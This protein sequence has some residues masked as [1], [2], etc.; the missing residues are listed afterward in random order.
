MVN[1]L[2]LK[3]FTVLGSD[4]LRLVLDW[5]NTERVRRMMSNPEKISWDNH[6]A[7]ITSLS[8]RVDCCY[9]LV[10]VGERPI[11]VIDLTEIAADGSYANP[12][13]YTGEDSPLGTGLLLEYSVFLTIFDRFGLRE[14]RSLVKKEQAEYSDSLVRIFN[15]VK[16][17]ETEDSFK[18][19][20]TDK[21]WSAVKSG[22]R[23]RLF[24]RFALNRVVWREKDG[25]IAEDEEA[26]S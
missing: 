9:Y 4:E 26:C 7:Y 19:L 2:I 21:N 16:I 11:G 12:G 22:L 13:L 5:R 8:D 18:M 20:L 6:I 15:A 17:G 23:T 14:A 1:S 25:D 24:R 3:N 10:Y